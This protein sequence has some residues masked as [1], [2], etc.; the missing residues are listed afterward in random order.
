MYRKLLFEKPLKM[1][2]LIFKHA[3]Y[4]VNSI[5]SLDYYKYS[6]YHPKF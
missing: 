4:L 5:Y 3:N 2:K 6:I 1:S